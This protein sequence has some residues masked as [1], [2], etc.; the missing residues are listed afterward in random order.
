MNIEVKIDSTKLIEESKNI[1]WHN[2]IRMFV[3]PK[4]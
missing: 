3:I 2:R 1:D 4:P